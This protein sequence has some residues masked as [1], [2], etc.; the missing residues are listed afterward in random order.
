MSASRLSYV[1]R[2]FHVA[3]AED[4]R[5]LSAQQGGHSEKGLLSKIASAFNCKPT[6]FEPLI[7]CMPVSQE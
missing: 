1:E 7:T 4:K 6:S 2:A 5:Q 3:E